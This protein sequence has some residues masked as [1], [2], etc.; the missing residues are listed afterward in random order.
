[1]QTLAIYGAGGL[2]RETLDLA[3]LIN[4][5]AKTFSEIYLVD[6]YNPNRVINNTR[7]ISFD[8]LLSKGLA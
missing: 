2:G 7:V 3:R 5:A 8:D 6:D 1:M 4:D